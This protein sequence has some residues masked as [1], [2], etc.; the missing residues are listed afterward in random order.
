MLRLLEAHEIDRVLKDNYK[1]WSPGLDR[2]R[3]RHYQWWQML[4]PWGRRNLEYFGF[5][6]PDGKLAASC[7]RY[8]FKY[9]SRGRVYN[10]AGIGAVF[11]E[12]DLRGNSYGLK[13]LEEIARLSQ[14]E[15]YDALLLNSDIDPAYYQRIGY[16]L[17]D[18]G[19][20]NV[21]LS[22]DWLRSSIKQMDA[23]SDRGLDESFVVRSVTAPDIAEMCKHHQRWLSRMSYGFKRSSDYW[24]YKLGRELYLFEHSKLNW[25]KLDIITDN[26]GKYMGG[27][28]LVEQSG[29]YMRVLEVIGPEPIKASLWGQIL[30]LAERRQARSLRAWK[31]VAPPLKGLNF[32]KRDW[33]FPMICPLKKELEDEMLSWL[34]IDPPSMLELDHF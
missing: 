29:P 3:Y 30:R 20:F 16:Y 31:L 9:Q 27:Y 32:Y 10:V 17:F 14:K 1:I 4:H 8:C 21:S 13:M 26:Y 28:A 19:A 24:S 23:L 2:A 18:A 7:K 22:R 33:S 6:T 25:P 12:E 34:H 5:F 11:V 15:G